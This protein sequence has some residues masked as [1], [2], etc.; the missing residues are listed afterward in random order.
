[1]KRLSTEQF[2]KA[3]TY[4]YQFSTAINGRYLRAQPTAFYSD[5]VILCNELNIH[6][7]LNC[8]QCLL[9]AVSKLGSLY[10]SDKAEMEAEVQKSEDATPQKSETPDEP[11]KSEEKPAKPTKPKKP[12]ETRS[13]TNKK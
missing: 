7:N 11:E 4:E 5:L 9:T 10:L 13:K 1:M 6:I 8:P 2:E 3:K 12:V